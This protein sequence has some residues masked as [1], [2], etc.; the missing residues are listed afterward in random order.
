MNFKKLSLL[1][2]VFMIGC[3]S[4]PA[5]TMPNE[6]AVSASANFY[7]IIST[8]GV[9][10]AIKAIKAC[11]DG[12]KERDNYL[13]CLS[14]DIQGQRFDDAMSKR[15]NQSGDSYFA[16]QNFEQ[17]LMLLERWYPSKSQ[18]DYVLKQVMA[19]LEQ[20]TKNEVAR[21]EGLQKNK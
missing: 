7:S 10:G 9:P 19:G 12:A 20:G 18:L 6:I 2:C 14:M 11:Y 17:R 1:A 15:T 5:T 8:D 3:K 21:V 16:A 13:F 4:I